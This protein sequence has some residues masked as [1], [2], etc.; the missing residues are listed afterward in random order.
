MH[1]L[2][3]AAAALM[4]AVSLAAAQQPPKPDPAHQPERTL[5]GCV[6]AERADSKNPDDTRIIYRL[7]VVEA[8]AAAARDTKPGERKTVSYELSAAEAMAVSKHVG[9]EVQVTGELLLPPGLAPGAGGQP[10]AER[11]SLPLPGEAKGTFKVTSLK[12]LAAKCR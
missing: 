5:Q 9:H 12:M 6:R 3:S 10:P 8:P 1:V 4:M 2:I 11:K 7:E